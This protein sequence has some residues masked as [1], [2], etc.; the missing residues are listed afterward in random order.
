VKLSKIYIHISR[1]ILESFQRFVMLAMF[2]L[3]EQELFLEEVN[4]A[5]VTS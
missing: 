1:G 4:A 3:S 5:E 2:S